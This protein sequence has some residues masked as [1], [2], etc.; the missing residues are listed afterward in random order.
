[1]DKF[2]NMNIAS[3]PA[4]WIKIGI[5]AAIFCFGAELLAK[6]IDPGTDPAPNIQE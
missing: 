1:M 5:M 6:A 4:N 3:H 2:I